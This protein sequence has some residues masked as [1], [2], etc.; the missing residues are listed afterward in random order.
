[1]DDKTFKAIQNLRRADVKLLEVIGLLDDM[2]NEV[3]RNGQILLGMEILEY[4]SDDA[5]LAYAYLG[6]A[7]TE[8]ETRLTD[9]AAN[10]EPCES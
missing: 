3:E 4:I 5:E 8:L 2:K 10:S 1:M 6:D 7:K 9:G